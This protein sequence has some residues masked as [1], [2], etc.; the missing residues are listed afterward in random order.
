VRGD[1]EIYERLQV[2]SLL[3]EQLTHI[4]SV[5]VFKEIEFYLCLTRSLYFGFIFI[6][7]LFNR[8]CTMYSITFDFVF[9]HLN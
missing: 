3:V 2:W 9:C 6:F 8:E 7:T 1:G 4:Y 5:G